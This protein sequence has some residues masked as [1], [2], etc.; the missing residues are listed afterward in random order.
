MILLN[1]EM[2]MSYNGWTNYATWL[3]KLEY[4][5]DCDLDT[6]VDTENLFDV[7]STDPDDRVGI[8]SSGLYTIFTDY[9]EENSSGLAQTLAKSAVDDVNF[10]EIAEHMIDDWVTEHPESLEV[11]SD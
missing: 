5:G 11:A 1:E 2:S 10:D 8:V 9:I 3:V 7:D 6:F 4:F